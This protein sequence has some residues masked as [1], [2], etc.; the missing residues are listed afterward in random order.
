MPVGQPGL[1]IRIQDHSR[2]CFLYH[3]SN[4][5]LRFSKQ[6]SVENHIFR[7]KP[8]CLDLCEISI[9]WYSRLCFGKSSLD[10]C[11][12]VGF[13]F[14]FKSLFWL[15]DKNLTF[16]MILLLGSK[17]RNWSSG[18][19][20]NARR[21]WLDRIRDRNSNIQLIMGFDDVL[22]Y[23]WFIEKCENWICDF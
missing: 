8:Y 15:A 21:V 20:V 9:T 7:G 12:R 14:E 23:I 16:W 5:G 22:T 3:E 11:W 6:V 19:V 2:I 17:M 4:S 13:N 18:A 1:K 10:S